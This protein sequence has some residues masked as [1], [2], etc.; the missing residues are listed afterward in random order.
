M[1]GLI[2]PIARWTSN[3]QNLQLAVLQLRKI[4]ANWNANDRLVVYA[5]SV[6]ASTK[7]NP[8]YTLS[9]GGGTKSA[10]FKGGQ[11][12]GTLTEGTTPLYAYVEKNG[13]DNQ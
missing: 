9:D 5:G 6:S 4:A 11:L 13:T 1:R 8:V 2:L 12:Q 10:T 3:F 7:S